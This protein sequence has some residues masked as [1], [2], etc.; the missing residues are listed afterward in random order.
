MAHRSS[1]LRPAG[2]GPPAKAGGATVWALGDSHAGHLQGMLYTLHERTGLGVHLIE[3]PGIAYPL[4]APFE[5]RVRIVNDLLERAKPGDIVLL[6]RIYLD[7]SEHYVLGD[8]A[9]WSTRVSELAAELDKK[10]LKLVVV[11]PPPIF[12]YEDVRA[13]YF[14]TFGIKP[15]S[16]DRAALMKSASQVERLLASALQ[17][18]RNAFVFDPFPTL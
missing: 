14:D 10:G 11:G 16:E 6:S 15:C 13:C 8:V 7:R 17:G 3:T 18:K 2:A 12:S 5:P 4:N 9:S 1:C